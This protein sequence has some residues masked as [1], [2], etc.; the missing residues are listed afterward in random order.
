[1]SVSESVNIRLMRFLAIRSCGVIDRLL[2]SAFRFQLSTFP[3]SPPSCSA[4]SSARCWRFEFPIS[5][6]QF[7]FRGELICVAGS[8]RVASLHGS[9]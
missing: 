6:A 2:L 5:E 1:M 7:Q 9:G 3:Q 8:F 4:S